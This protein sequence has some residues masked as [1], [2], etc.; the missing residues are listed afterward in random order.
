MELKDIKRINQKIYELDVDIT[1]NNKMMFVSLLIFCSLNKDFRNPNKTTSVINFASSN[2][3][4]DDLIGLAIIEIEKLDLLS[5]TV[6]SVKSSLNII[7]GANTKLHRD[8]E[9]LQKFVTN[10]VAN[11]LPYL[12]E[13]N[14]LFFETLYMEIDKKANNSDKGIT[15]TPDF[16]AQLMVDLANLDYKKDVV[17]DLC[18]GTGLFSLLSYSTMLKNL[19]TDLDK[20]IITDDEHKAYKLRLFNSIIANDY[21]PKMLTLCLANFLS[22]SL[23]SKM[24]LNDDIFVLKR[25]SFTFRNDKGEKVNLHPNKGILNPPYEDTYKPIE[26]ILKTIELIKEDETMD[27][28]VVVIAP[29]QKFGQKRETFSKIL[30]LARLETVIKMQD[31][32]FTDS[33]QTPSTCIFV[34]N[35]QKS[36]TKEDI[37][38][39]YDFRDTGYIYLKDSGMVDKTRTHIEKKSHLMQKISSAKNEEYHS[40]FI[41]NWNNFYEIDKEIEITASINPDKIRHSKEDADIT[42]ENI[43]IKKTLNEKLNL[44]QSVDNQLVDTNKLFEKY[45]IDILCENMQ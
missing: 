26:V 17:A 19:S 39:Y 1:R 40:T 13:E 42:I 12:A 35:L 10:F 27:Q 28:K 44:I 34:F 22:K 16:A 23:N 7:H 18:S 25:S 24:I 14:I 29:P 41:R 11:D 33:G 4:I 15:L 5:Q 36:H 8:R 6:D 31:D 3:P 30:N 37:I 38:H 20:K 32:L 21:E 9:K 2:N 45:M 43:I